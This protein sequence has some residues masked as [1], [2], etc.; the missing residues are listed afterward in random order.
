[1]EHIQPASCMILQTALH[2]GE[3]GNRVATR[4]QEPGSPNRLGV[5]GGA[6]QVMLAVVQREMD[7]E[8]VEVSLVTTASL[9]LTSAVGGG[10]VVGR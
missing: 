7:P 6:G 8:C 1:M 4:W 10:Q 5:G 9:P 2:P 3:L